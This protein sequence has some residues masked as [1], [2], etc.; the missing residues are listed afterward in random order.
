M[1]ER[2]YTIFPAPSRP[3][4]RSS[5]IVTN[6][7]WRWTPKQMLKYPGA[8]H[9]QNGALFL[10]YSGDSDDHNYMTGRGRA[11]VKIWVPSI[12]NNIDFGRIIRYRLVYSNY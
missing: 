11:N 4:G 7:N 5:R 6:R 10:Y 1:P 12:A 2:A 8:R 3:S 9:H